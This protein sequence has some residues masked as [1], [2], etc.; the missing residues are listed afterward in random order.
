MERYHDDRQ[1]FHAYAGELRDT[2]KTGLLKEL[3]QYPHF[4]VYQTV[5]QGERLQKIP[6]NARTGYRADP[7]NP[8]EGSDT[9][10]ALRA[11]ASGY[12]HGLGFILNATPFTALDLDHCTHPNRR[13]DHWAQQ[14]IQWVNSYA[15]YSVT[16]GAH[17]LVK[18]AHEMR[19][20]V[21]AASE[22]G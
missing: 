13:I 8:K 7:T 5:R 11:L 15:E 21:L 12:F 22:Q 3:R 19:N 6:Y 20:E 9:M 4:L 1:L 18:G 17:I 10:T 14:T 16:D 2:F